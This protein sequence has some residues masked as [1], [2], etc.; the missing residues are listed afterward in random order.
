MPSTF[1]VNTQE[2]DKAKENLW[3]LLLLQRRAGWPNPAMGSRRK[4]RLHSNRVIIVRNKMQWKEG[5]MKLEREL[6]VAL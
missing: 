1:T 3:E 6:R 5:E 4:V 2:K